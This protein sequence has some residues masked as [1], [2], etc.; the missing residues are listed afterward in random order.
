MFAFA[1]IL[2]CKNISA[3]TTEQASIK[4]ESSFAIITDSLT[5]NNCKGE[6]LAY[7]DILEKEGLPTYIVSANWKSPE[8]VKEILKE[9]YTTKHL[10]GT[11]FVGDIPIAMITK[12]Q[13]L[14]SAFKMDERKYPLISVSV[15]SDRFYDDFDL[16]FVSIKDSTKGNMFFYEL[17]PESLPYIESDIYSARIVPQASN[18]DKYEQISLYL[19]KVVAAHKQTDCFDSFVSYTG[20][21]SYSNSLIAWKSERQIINEQFG[22]L[23]N[24]TNNS[25]FTRYSM[26]DYMKDDVIKELRRKDLDF[27][28]FHEH[29]DYPRMYLSGTPDVREPDEYLKTTLRFWAKKNGINYAKEKAEKFGLDSTWYCD[30][31]DPKVIIEDSLTD[32]KQ[33]IILEEI[34]NISPNVKFVIFDACY[35]G[36]F[37]EKDFI[38]GK[39]IMSPGECITTFANSVNVLQDKA[40]FELMGLFKLGLRIGQWAKYNN[41][42][43]SHIIGD[44]TYYFK[45]S[46]NSEDINK[47]INNN[48]LDYWI[49]RVNDNNPEIQNIALIKLFNG[50][51]KN[52]SNLLLDKYIKSKYAIVRYNA[53]VL[54]ERLNDNNYREVLKRAVYD[55]FEFIRRIAV[56]R[57]GQSG[58]DEFL[59]YLVDAYVKDINAARVIFNVSGAIVCFDKDKAAE[60]VEEYFSNKNFYNAQNYKKQ[61]LDLINDN[62]SESSL[63]TIIDKSAKRGYRISYIQYLRNRPYHQITEDLIKVMMDKT[64][65]ELIRTMIAESFA[66]YELSVKKEIILNACKSLLSN[67]DCP[68]QMKEALTS[69]C[70]RLSSVK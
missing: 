32:L 23:F 39:F 13:F 47:I 59:P 22:D 10:E 25:K 27:M 6:L 62:P 46:E 54:L 2:V 31:N 14:T 37:R 33:G 52:I 40:A 66:W 57:M 63:S 28:V 24:Y 4:G 35:N 3:Q 41:I 60:V 51:Y 67:N 18:G 8:Q 15:P 64:Q 42:L 34:N 30:F 20:H 55:S 44:P 50:N 36:D 45:A 29:G 70:N 1:L 5:M 7:K 68:E 12:A 61:L 21:G 48:N 16:T 56:T 17:S 19:K 26:A 9:L 11:V 58:Y 53:M 38:A 69:A 43:E 65:D 49:D